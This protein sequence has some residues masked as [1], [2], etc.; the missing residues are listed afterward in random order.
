MGVC[1]GRG[2][3]IPAQNGRFAE[4]VRRFYEVIVPMTAAQKA[5]LL[6]KIN[7]S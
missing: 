6:E 5:S 3:G 7:L 2:S 4:S 1:G